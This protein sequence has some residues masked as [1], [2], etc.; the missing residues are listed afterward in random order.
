[1]A[2]V[3]AVAFVSCDSKSKETAETTPADSIEALI[4]DETE[5]ITLDTASAPVDSVTTVKASTDSVPV[6]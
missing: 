2:V 5:T 6:K 1:M 4:V 3:A